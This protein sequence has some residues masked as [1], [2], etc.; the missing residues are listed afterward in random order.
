MDP[1]TRR[2]LLEVF[3]APTNVA[4][5]GTGAVL[6][7]P[8]KLD[9]ELASK[10]ISVIPIDRI[11]R[12]LGVVAARELADEFERRGLKPSDYRNLEGVSQKIATM[13]AKSVTKSEVF[14]RALREHLGMRGG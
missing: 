2:R 4:P 3:G 6:T 14:D 5:G 8:S 10:V 12:D 13:I 9:M 1:D 11:L 7:R